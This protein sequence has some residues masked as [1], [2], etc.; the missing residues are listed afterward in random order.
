VIYLE[1]EEAVHRMLKEI[2]VQEKGDLTRRIRDVGHPNSSIISQ[3]QFT[4]FVKDELHM[5]DADLLRLLRVSKFAELKKD[6]TM[7]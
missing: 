7:K 4:S 5:D 6:K 1:D 3:K 2:D